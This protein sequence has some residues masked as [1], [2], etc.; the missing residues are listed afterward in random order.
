M[1]I[2]L[3]LLYVVILVIMSAASFIQLKLKSQEKGFNQLHDWLNHSFHEKSVSPK[4]HHPKNQKVVDVVVE[5]MPETKATL[6]HTEKMRQQFLKMEQVFRQ[7][8]SHTFWF[9]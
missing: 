6:S 7:F 8:L 4:R 1:N 9:R 2:L 3:F 5:E